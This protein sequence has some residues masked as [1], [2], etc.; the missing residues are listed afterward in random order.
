LALRS[1][2]TINGRFYT[3]S[4]TLVKGHRRVT[5]RAKVAMALSLLVLCGGLGV[6]TWYLSGQS[7][8]DADSASSV[9]SG[10]AGVVFGVTGVVLG[11]AG[12]RQSSQDQEGPT[13]EAEP[14]VVGERAV[15]VHG[16]T[17]GPVITGDYATVTDFSPRVV[18]LL[19]LV[20]A[21]AAGASITSVVLALRDEQ[22]LPAT[23][24]VGAYTVTVRGSAIGGDPFELQGELRVRAATDGQPYEWCMKV[25]NPW[26]AP[27]PGA[28]WFGTNGTCFGKGADRAVTVVSESAG[29]HIL[30][31]VN[32]PA[33]LDE[34]LNGFTATS[35]ILA[36]AY[37]PDGGEVRFRP[38]PSRLE[39][40]LS[41]QGLE[42]LTGGSTRGT[43]TATFTAALV[44]D[45]PEA[46]VSSPI[47]P[48]FGQTQPPTAP[49]IDGIRYT[50]RTIISFVDIA[51]NP[52]FV[53]SARSRFAGAVFIIDARD[54]GNFVYAPPN[55][56]N[57]VF[58]IVG[59][60][61]GDGPVYVITGSRSSGDGAAATTAEI[62]GTLD[63]SSADP[64]ARLI[65]RTTVAGI[66]TNS[67]YQVE[68]ILQSR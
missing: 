4:A 63:T 50:V 11:L 44:S 9:L 20:V 46:L 29:E 53:N 38:A 41:L 30:T 2:G 42:A 19:G 34:N 39:G 68:A 15:I 26:G 24:Q 16:G 56:R 65:L 40:T 31:P 5:R 32:P 37:V 1:N 49:D 43:F 54:G 66:N 10:F 55:S 27:K 17:R 6:W 3:Y 51:D 21:L 57:D 62:G 22:Q 61:T 52:E 23:V 47:D 18:W 35:G 67:E 8:Q 60:V 64:V 12:L 48:I 13:T 14:S 58:P 7:L 36:G 25:G 45:D 28:I 59:T 33:R